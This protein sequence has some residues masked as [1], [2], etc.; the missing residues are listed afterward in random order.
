MSADE[1]WRTH[2]V[3]CAV[4]SMRAVADHTTVASAQKQIRS[5]VALLEEAHETLSAAILAEESQR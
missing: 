4:L 5:A 3:S 2:Q 1:V